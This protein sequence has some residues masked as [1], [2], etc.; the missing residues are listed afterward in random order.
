LLRRVPLRGIEAA[1]DGPRKA[2]ATASMQCS[3]R[4]MQR[5]T[6]GTVDNRL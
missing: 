6:R 2:C 4:R 1:R 3:V 5:G